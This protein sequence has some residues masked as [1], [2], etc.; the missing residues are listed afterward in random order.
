[1]LS[2]LAVC[3]PPG[4][5]GAAAPV[6]SKA[7]DLSKFSPRTPSSAVHTEYVVETNHLG[8]V[9]RVRS[10]RPSPD[11]PFNA[12]T[13][14]N[15]LQA[16]IRTTAGR[17]VAGTYRLAYDYDPRTKNVRRS[18]ALV[19]AG[20]VDGDAPGAVIVEAEKLRR[21]AQKAA[22]LQANASP[23]PDFKH[24]TTHRH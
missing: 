9:A 15:A 24:I 22:E 3:A 5:L 6:S 4:P 1:M 16:F 8:Q 13:Y 17:A 23:L 19:R 2:A 14:G 10:V 20:G 7:P 11:P 12:L 21:A 18:V